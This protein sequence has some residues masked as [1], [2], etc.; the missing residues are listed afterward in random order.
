MSSGVVRG[1]DCVCRRVVVSPTLPHAGPRGAKD[2]F[3]APE[4]RQPVSCKARI[5][6]ALAVAW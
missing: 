1:S 5:N 3:L 4:S 2:N 6:T